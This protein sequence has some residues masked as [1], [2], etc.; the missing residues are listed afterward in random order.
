MGVEE[1]DSEVKYLVTKLTIVKGLSIYI[2]QL[3]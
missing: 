2:K 1:E 3:Y